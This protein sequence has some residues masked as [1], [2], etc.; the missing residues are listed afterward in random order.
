M[1]SC[2]RINQGGLGQIDTLRWGN[3]ERTQPKR[4]LSWQCDTSLSPHSPG[5]VGE[6]M[7]MSVLSSLLTEYEVARPHP[8]IKMIKRFLDTETFVIWTKFS[9]LPV[10]K[11]VILTNIGAS[12]ENFANMTFPRQ[13]I[14]DHQCG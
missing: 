11:I 2:I 5:G 3:G 6:I 12:S 4:A 14:S 1:A 9:S 10:L 7:L 13:C 8:E